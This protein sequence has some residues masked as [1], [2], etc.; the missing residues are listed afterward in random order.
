MPKNY[1]QWAYD[2]SPPVLRTLPG[3]AY[4]G[5]KA[6]LMDFLMMAAT[7]AVRTGWIGD[8]VGPSWDGIGPT[9]RDMLLPRYPGESFNA[10]HGRLKE[11][12]IDW[13]RAGV[14]EIL[15]K[16]LAALGFPGG[17]VQYHTEWDGYPPPWWSLFSIFY[18]YGTH[19]FG[20]PR[21]YDDGC[22]Y[23]DGTIYDVTNITPLQY[24]TMRGI[25]RK[26]KPAHWVCVAVVF[27][28]SPGGERVF[29]GM[30]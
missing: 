27:E 23:D 15:L 10:Y 2:I 19:S 14:E 7:H 13:P 12:W 21:K 28:V 4:A 16:N 1:R 30:D 26:F 17:V 3:R 24:V 29:L 6:M 9:G 11:A 25:I 5:A 8:S 20:P 18:A 22:A